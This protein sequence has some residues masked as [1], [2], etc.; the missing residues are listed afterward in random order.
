MTN[1]VQFCLIC[2]ILKYYANGSDC[3]GDDYSTSVFPAWVVARSLTRDIHWISMDLDQVWWISM[4]FNFFQW[5]LMDF[6]DFN[7]FQL[8]LM[9]FN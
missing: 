4:D 3:V 2:S 5:A 8:I 6:F 9:D 7:G 1:F